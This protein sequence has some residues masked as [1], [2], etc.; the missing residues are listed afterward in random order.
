MKN[1]LAATLAATALIVGAGLATAQQTNMPG[2]TVKTTEAPSYQEKS[3]GAA[4]KTE[5]GTMQKS[6]AKQG[7]SAV[8]SRGH[9]YGSHAWMQSPTQG[10]SAAEKKKQPSGQAAPSPSASGTENQQP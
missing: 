3:T 6:P 1:S 4:S 8:K 10:R 7:R 2:S 9:H 5:P